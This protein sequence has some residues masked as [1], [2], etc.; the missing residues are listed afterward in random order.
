MILRRIDQLMLTHV[1]VRIT[2][3]ELASR[4]PTFTVGVIAAVIAALCQ[5]TRRASLRDRQ[6]R[7]R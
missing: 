4:F 3:K 2:V 7:S 5:L 6:R 1:L